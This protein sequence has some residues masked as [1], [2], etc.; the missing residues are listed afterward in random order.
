MTHSAKSIVM[1][2]AVAAA[3]SL[4]MI[5]SASAVSADLARKCRDLAIKAYPPAVAGSRS[6]TAEAE[7]DFYRACVAKG[8]NIQTEPV[9]N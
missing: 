6:G 8:G 1:A 7:R 4:S 9:K 5:P 2:A 3:C